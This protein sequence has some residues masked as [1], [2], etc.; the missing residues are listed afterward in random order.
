[1][2]SKGLKEYLEEDPSLTRK[3]TYE[4]LQ[5]NIVSCTDLDD[6]IE[7]AYRTYRN[8]IENINK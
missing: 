3:L 4:E 7:E 6:S 2:K 8:F 1:M 5:N